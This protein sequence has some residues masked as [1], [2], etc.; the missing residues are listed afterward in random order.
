MPRLVLCLVLALACAGAGGC[1]G[2]YGVRDRLDR[3]GLED[4]RR[5]LAALREECR[6]RDAG[7]NARIDALER[8]R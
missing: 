2:S 1:A 8:T 5:E 7:I 6:K 4:V 3:I